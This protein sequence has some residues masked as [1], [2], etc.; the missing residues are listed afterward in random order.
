M[1]EDED[2]AKF[3]ILPWALGK[4]W[5]KRISFFYHE[6]Q[7]LFWSIDCR[8]IVSKKCCDDVSSFNFCNKLHFKNTI[9]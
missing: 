2:D 6:K 4:L 9:L 8:A 5:K 7:M 3:E 1:E